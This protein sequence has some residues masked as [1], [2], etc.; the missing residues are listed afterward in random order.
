MKRQTSKKTAR[1]ASFIVCC[2]VLQGLK[3]IALQE[4]QKSLGQYASVIPQLSDNPE[5]IFLR[6][7]GELHSLLELRTV[8]AVYIVEQFAIARP[9]ALLGHQNYQHL[10]QQIQAVLKLHPSGAFS[11]LRISAAGENS[12]VFNT[13]CESLSKVIQLPF[14]QDDGDLLLRIRLSSIQATSWEVLIRLTPRPLSTRSW[15]TFHMQGALNATL[16]AAMIE[17]SQ[18]NS[19]DRFL[20]LM[21][22][23]G[24]LLIE[25]IAQGPAAVIVGVDTSVEALRGALKNASVG[26]IAQRILLLNADAMYTPF[27]EETFDVICADLPWGQLT[28][29]HEQNAILYPKFL[30]EVTHIA[31]PNARLVVLTHEIALF[32]GVLE[33]YKKYWILQDVVKVF[34][35]GLHPRVY[36]LTKNT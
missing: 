29:S 9:R 12:T 18:P 11:G 31:A 7:S 4:I 35:G 10:L 26:N 33:D 22:G 34:Q 21:C 2:E 32:E 25:R 28:G 14:K 1:N 27:L 24:T 13:L 16:A 17:M 19:S 3:P 6:Y 8:V 36:V 15:R 20:N 5:Y 23:S 30:T